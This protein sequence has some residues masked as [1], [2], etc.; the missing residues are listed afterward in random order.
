[1][2]LVVEWTTMSAPS[3][4]GCWRIG[5]ANVLS[6]TVRAPASRASEAHA[7]MSVTLRSGFDGVSSQRSFAPPAQSRGDGC[8][9]RRVDERELDAELA[10]DLREDAPRAAVEV[11]RRD[12][13]IAAA[14]RREDAV[15]RG[16]PAR[17]R[18]PVLGTLELRDAALERLAR[19]VGG[20]RVRVSLVDARRRL[21]ERRGLID[22]DGDRAGALVVRLAG[23]DGES[24]SP[25]AHLNSP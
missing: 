5:V 7:R 9:V 20:A 14:E 1:M 4:S 15:D 21:L 22:G 3:A 17:V 16:H 2:Y 25:I 10:V 13:A 19:R 6:T 11:A 8:G 23:V 12:D 18:E 24:A